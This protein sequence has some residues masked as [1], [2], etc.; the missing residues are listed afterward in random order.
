MYSRLI[1]AKKSER[2]D[3]ILVL[4]NIERK[5]LKGL[6]ASRNKRMRRMTLLLLMTRARRMLV[7]RI[8]IP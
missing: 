8:T 3:P 5:E 4:M 7:L 2:K 1:K 6:L